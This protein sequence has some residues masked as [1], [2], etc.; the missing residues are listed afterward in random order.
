[1]DGAEPERTCGRPTATP[2]KWSSRPGRE[3]LLGWRADRS[4]RSRL[5]QLCVGRRWS[6]RRL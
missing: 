4:R 1:M 6:H 2:A 3:A 5:R